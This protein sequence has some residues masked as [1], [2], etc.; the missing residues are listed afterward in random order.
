MNQRELNREVSQKTGE[1]V[2]TIAAFGFVPLT[3]QPYER[4]PLTIDWD[5]H[6]LHRNVSIVEQR[7]PQAVA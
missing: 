5:E 7:Q 3:G 6:E 1:T 4:E 2:S